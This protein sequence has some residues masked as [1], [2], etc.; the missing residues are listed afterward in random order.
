[1]GSTYRRGNIYWLK[2]YRH[3][4]PYQE[5]SRSTKEVD[6]KR[7][8]KRREGEISEG[9][10]PGIY[11]DKVRFDE[12]AE[13]FL[14][15]YRINNRKSLLRAQESV[16]HLKR[17]FEDMRVTSITTPRINNYVEMRLAEGAANGTINR[18]LAALKRMLN[19]GAQQTPPKVNRVPYIPMLKEAPPRQGFFE[20]GEFLALRIVL[21]E[22]LKGFATFAY[23]TGWRK[24][25]IEGLT[26]SQVNLDQGSVKLE[27][28]STK[29]DESRIICLGEELRE[30]IHRQQEARKKSEKL[31]PYVFPNSVGTGRIKDFSTSWD[32]ACKKAGI[33]KK[34]FH[35]L[36][37]TAITNMVNADIPEKI[38]MT[39]SGHKTRAVFDRYN[40]VK[41]DALERAAVKQ[42]VYLQEQ[43]VTFSA[44]VRD[45][46][47]K[48]NTSN[49]G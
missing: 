14:S 36:R 17:F 41:R 28:G 13:D 11:F 5:S 25:E 34:L 15:D 23:K 35:D 48:G 19:V 39:I 22:Y 33:G 44:T 4:K 3:G 18:E 30:V 8:L 6:A 46:N 43:K 27:A 32:K 12:L 2:Y 21:P 49:N 7:L 47:K 1:M 38:V 31:T 42:E 10:L 20:H 29:N 37:R 40:I 16:H 26:W 24:A 45:F 9:K